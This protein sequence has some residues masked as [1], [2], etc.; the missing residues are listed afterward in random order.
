[1]NFLRM[2]SNYKIIRKTPCKKNLESDWN[3]LLSML[4]K[5]PQDLK[6]KIWIAQGKRPARHSIDGTGGPNVTCRAQ[7]FTKFN[8]FKYRKTDIKN[9]YSKENQWKIYYKPVQPYG[10]ENQSARSGGDLYNLK[11]SST[12]KTLDKKQ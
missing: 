6:R 9:T 10:K 5:C 1:M 12:R 3:K 4:T 11:K 2:Q 8:L 7:V